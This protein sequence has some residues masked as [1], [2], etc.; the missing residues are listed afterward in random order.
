MNFTKKTIA[1]GIEYARALPCLFGLLQIGVV[2][3]FKQFFEVFRIWLE[4]KYDDP[5]R[6]AIIQAA[7]AAIIN[8]WPRIGHRASEILEQLALCVDSTPERNTPSDPAVA[9]KRADEIAAVIREAGVCAALI[10]Q[11]RYK[12]LPHPLDML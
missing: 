12:S 8:G 2:R 6:A 1:Q 3:H 9:A 10:M 7:Q 5:S 11:V 4:E